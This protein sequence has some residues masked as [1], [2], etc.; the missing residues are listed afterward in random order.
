MYTH[1]LIF[2]CCVRPELLPGGNVYDGITEIFNDT[3]K[4]CDR[5]YLDRYIEIKYYKKPTSDFKQFQY[6][7]E[8]K[9]HCDR[10]SD[11]PEV[12]HLFPSQRIK[13]RCYI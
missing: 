9:I 8:C 2:K 4:G 12:T 1:S 10:C 11:D 3:T 5:Y 13:I 7:K 6:F